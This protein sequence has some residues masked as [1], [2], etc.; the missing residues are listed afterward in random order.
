MLCINCAELKEKIMLFCL[1]VFVSYRN[2]Q[3]I[4]SVCKKRMKRVGFSVLRVP[5]YEHLYWMSKLPDKCQQPGAKFLLQC[6]QLTTDAWCSFCCNLW[7]AHAHLSFIQNAFIVNKGINCTHQVWVM[8][9]K[10]HT[11]CFVAALES[12]TSSILHHTLGYHNHH[13]SDLYS[14]FFMRLNGQ[15]IVQ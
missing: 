4:S 12:P 9:K 1:T 13:P 14:E 5:G 11:V 15:I 10:L 8:M 2:S 3:G 6:W 7:S